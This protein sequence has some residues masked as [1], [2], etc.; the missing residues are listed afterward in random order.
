MSTVSMCRPWTVTPFDRPSW[1]REVDHWPATAMEATAGSATCRALPPPSPGREVTRLHLQQL[2]DAGNPYAG[3]ALATAPPATRFFVNGDGIVSTTDV[4]KPRPAPDEDYEHHREL[5]RE[6][7]Q[8]RA[9]DGDPHAQWALSKADDTEHLFVE[10]VR[11]FPYYEMILV[12]YLDASG[13]DVY[14]QQRREA[15]DV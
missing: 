14:E 7:V 2:A 1:C 12:R 11:F 8:A 10:A 9:D 5:T 15:S 6:E 4:P 13:L 3:R